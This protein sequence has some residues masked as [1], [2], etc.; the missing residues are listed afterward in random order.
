MTFLVS[1][2]C[3]TALPFGNVLVARCCLPLEKNKHTFVRIEGEDIRCHMKRNFF[4]QM[5]AILRA[6]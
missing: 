1:A 2:V 6:I 4:M 5:A 3:R